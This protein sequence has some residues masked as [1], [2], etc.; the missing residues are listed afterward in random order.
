MSRVFT[1]RAATNRD[2]PFLNDML[3]EAAAVDAGMREIGKAA[4]LAMPL[5]SK[6]LDDWGRPGDGGVIGIGDDG[7]PLGAAWYRIF[8]ADAPGYGF[9]AVDIPELSIG[10]SESARGKGVGG[11]LIAALLTM[12][13]DEAFPGVSLSVDRENPAVALYERHGFRDAGLSGPEE[14]SVT[15]VTRFDE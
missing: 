12:A 1:I 8:P 2:L 3:W 5:V 14:T 13:K 9:V 4:A 7:A 15:M 11:A 6:Y 10:V